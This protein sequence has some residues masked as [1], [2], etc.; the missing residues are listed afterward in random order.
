MTELEPRTNNDQT[1]GKFQGC[2]DDNGPELKP[3][4]SQHPQTLIRNYF[5]DGDIPF[6]M[7]TTSHNKETIAKPKR[8]EA[9]TNQKPFERVPV[10]VQSGVA[11]YSTVECGQGLG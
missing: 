2:S 8:G 11:R 6:H 9:E 7:P 3:K 5:V 4:Q 1:G 10:L